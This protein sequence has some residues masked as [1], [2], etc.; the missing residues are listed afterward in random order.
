MTSILPTQQTAPAGAALL[1]QLGN[2]GPLASAAGSLGLK[3][4][5]D[6]Q[7]AL[8]KSRTVE[9]AMINRFHLMDEYH[10]KLISDARVKLEHLVEIESSTKDPLIRISAMDSDPQRAADLANGYVEELKKLTSTLAVTE[11]AQRRVFFEEQLQQAKDNLAKAEEDLKKTQ[12]KTGLLQLDSQTRAAIESAVSLRAQVVAK[13]VEISS[14]QL[15]ATGENPQLQIA[16]QQLAALQAQLAKMGSAESGTAPVLT[17]GIMQQESLEYIRKLRD[18]RYFETIFEL[19]ARQLEVAKVDEARQGAMIQVVDKAVKPDHHS[20]PKRTFI[21]LGS[22]VLGFL[23]GIGW[24]VSSEA[25][26]RAT[27]NPDER[28][29]LEILRSELWSKKVRRAEP[30]QK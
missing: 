7:V 15:S 4:P 10:I 20:S 23:I 9:D 1:A 8:L 14:L 22:I 16:E 13:E 17:N 3:N 6:L 18:V 30:A 12:Q 26:R 28:A 27:R 21:V 2:L 29:R 25:I 19:L 5:N 24:A 11:A